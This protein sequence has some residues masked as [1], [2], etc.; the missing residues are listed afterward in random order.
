MQPHETIVARA[1]ETASPRGLGRWGSRL[2]TSFTP[3]RWPGGLVLQLVRPP[4]V[5]FPPTRCGSLVHPQ[6][7]AHHLV[8]HSSINPSGAQAGFLRRARV[9]SARKQIVD[10]FYY[11]RPCGFHE[12]LCF[13][14]P[15]AVCC[16]R[17]VTRR[18]ASLE[19]GGAT[20]VEHVF[21]HVMELS[22]T[23][24]NYP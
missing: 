9:L 7:F 2:T 13:L 10:Q 11:K 21:N 24:N 5:R 22:Q 1:G 20:F 15:A 19:A 4:R 16:S 18:P 17:F 8:Q 12:F 23:I 14:R 6:P 3:C